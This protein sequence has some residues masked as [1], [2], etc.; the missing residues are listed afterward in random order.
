MR[1]L[2]FVLCCHWAAVAVAQN[3]LTHPGVICCDQIVCPGQNIQPIQ[4]SVAITPDNGQVNVEYAWFELIDDT[5][6]AS[7]TRWRKIS[8]TNT[9][10]FLPT[11]INSV[12]G[13]FFMR[14]ARQVGTL[15]YL[16]SNI[17]TVKLFDGD[18]DPC[19]TS[20]EEPSQ[21]DLFSC[22]P[23]PATDLVRIEVKAPVR[24]ISVINS[25]GLTLATQRGSGTYAETP[26]FFEVSQYPTGLYLARV[27]FENGQIGVYKFMKQ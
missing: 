10:T 15:P 14:A 17:V 3:T 20:S 24:E 18:V 26:Y 16:F 19:T 2:L 22:Y 6:T 13:G 25:A 23:N 8:D 12:F 7:G 5:T 4:Q 11:Q 21:T 1:R 9:T 27:L